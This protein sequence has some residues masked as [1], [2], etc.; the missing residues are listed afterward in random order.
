LKNSITLPRRY[1]KELK[2]GYHVG[3]M[4]KI[5]FRC[6]SSRNHGTGHV[7]RSFALAEVF[8]LNNWDV[9]FSGDFDEPQWILGLLNKIDN[10]R[11]EKVSETIEQN[12]NYE[13]IVFDSY[14][15][16]DNEVDI[17]GKL[18]KFKISIVDDFSPKI[19]SDIYVSTLPVRY[20]PQFHGVSKYLFGPE[21]ALIRRGLSIDNLKHRVNKGSNV[22]KTLGLFSG[23][24]AKIE[25]LEIILK[26][27]LPKISGWNIKIFS[28]QLELK[29]LFKDVAKLEVIQ[30]NPE[31]Y[32][33]L[34]DVNLVVS[35]ASVSSWEF[36]SMGITLAVYGIYENQKSAYDF[37]VNSHFA[38]GLG[39]VENYKELVLDV[40]NLDRAIKKAINKKLDP[41]YMQKTIDGNGPSRIY[42]KVMKLI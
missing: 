17:I 19:N 29:T 14:S 26:Q 2:S 18:G 41:L 5:L 40:D 13:I 11:I 23:G 35:S 33:D 12:R 7:T 16:D 22:N 10:L 21:Y 34:K 38:E 27:M 24:S 28:D 6:S 39:C 32:D 3:Q 25:F 20:L 9:T 31:F 4:N 42:E 15:F 1:S 36:I 30:P 37:I 8:A